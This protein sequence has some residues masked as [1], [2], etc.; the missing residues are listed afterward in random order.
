MIAESKIP[1]QDHDQSQET[2][3]VLQR[4]QEHQTRLG[5]RGHPVGGVREEHQVWAWATFN[6]NIQDHGCIY[7]NRGPRL[8]RSADRLLLWLGVGV[9]GLGIC[10]TARRRRRVP[11]LGSFVALWL[12]FALLINKAPNYTRLLIT[13]P[14]VAYLVTQAVRWLAGRWRSVRHGPAAIVGAVLVIVVVSNLAIAWD[15][16]QTGRE[17][18]ETIGN[19]GRYVEAHKDIPGEQFFIDTLQQY[20]EEAWPGSPTRGRWRSLPPARQSSSSG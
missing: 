9:V 8:R 18:G 20:V 4:G 3:F 15:F 6:N 7:A 17:S 1:L 10:R 16:V 5:V 13:L 14:F 2:F 12:S 19:T 11:A